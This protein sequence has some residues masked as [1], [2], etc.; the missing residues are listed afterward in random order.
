M[1]MTS[2]ASLNVSMDK[3]YWNQRAKRLG[4]TGYADPL[5]LAFD[6]LLRVRT[7]FSLIKDRAPKLFLV[8]AYFR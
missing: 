7:V 8:P 2:L 5:L 3:D 1:K 4:T 6:Q